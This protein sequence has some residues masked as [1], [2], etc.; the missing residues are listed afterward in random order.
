MKP[1]PQHIVLFHYFSRFLEPAA[2]KNIDVIPLK[3][4]HL[5]TSVYPV[6]EDRGIMADVDFLVRPEDFNGACVLLE[7]LGF[8]RRERGIDASLS[9]EAG[10][11]KEIVRDHNI[12][13]EVHRYL[14]DPKRFCLDHEGLW[15]RS[16]ASDFDGVPCRRL[17]DEDHFLFICLHMAIHRL[18]VLKRTVRDLEL[19]IIHGDLDLSVV[20]QRAKEWKITRVLWLFLKLL[21]E[22]NSKL[23]IGGWAAAIAPP[24]PV[25]IAIRRLVPSKRGTAIGFL[26]HR[27]QAAILWPVLFDSPKQLA[28]FITNHP[29]AQ[30]LGK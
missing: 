18:M 3:G 13:F 5:L 2:K 1:N 7:E 22:S 24:T 9:H 27:L 19:L 15:E 11:Y 30:R 25:Q 16:I 29:V 17:T 26:H 23:K 4:A 28:K 14:L 10:F 12:L 8:F 20:I 21:E 6:D